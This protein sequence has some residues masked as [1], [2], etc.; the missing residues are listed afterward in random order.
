MAIDPKAI[1]IGLTGPFG[2]GCTTAAK[3]LERRHSY[4]YFR[5]S[6][7][8]LARWK[9]AHGRK[10][11][12]RTDLQFL[13][14]QI[15]R[16]GKS[17]G[18]LIQQAIKSLETDAQSFT[19]IVFDGI[20][21]VGEIES[22]KFRFAQRFYLFALECPTSVRWERVKPSYK[23]LEQFTLENERDRDQEDPYGQQ[24]ELC[25]DEAD[26]LLKNDDDVKVVKLRKKLVEYIDLV[27]G[28]KPRYATPR[29]ILMNLAYS[30]G[31]G[32]K[33]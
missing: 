18:A 24:V 1:V 19:R 29:E 33:C 9:K 20:R 32:S 31:H 28:A 6:D 17:P 2:S 22:L 5:L 7:L 23:S 11:P 30:A 14:N 15:R 4:K 27:T 21:N 16:E 13:G 25:V 8:I 12:T 26:V 3:Y 10:K